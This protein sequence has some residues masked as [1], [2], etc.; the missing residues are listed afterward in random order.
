MTKTQKVVFVGGVWDL[1]HVGHLNILEKAKRY[2]TILIVG[3]STDEL[4]LRYKG[5]YPV[6]PLAQ[7][8]RILKSLACVDFV[9]SQ[10]VLADV[11]L[12]ED[13]DVDVFV[14]G[15]DWKDKRNPPEGY[16]WIKENLEMIF[17]P[18]TEGI[19]STSI[20][21]ELNRRPIL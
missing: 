20:K 4:V 7:R 9:V 13:W 17:L 12:L 15:E 19:S 11:G 10:S 5:I 3:V 2:G 6:I 21:K 8:M 14:T 18:R 1:F 16:A